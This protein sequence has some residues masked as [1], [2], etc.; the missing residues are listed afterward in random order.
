MEVDIDGMLVN[1]QLPFKKSINLKK[2][3]IN[4]FNFF[5]SHRFI[6]ISIYKKV[7]KPITEKKIRFI[8][9]NFFKIDRFFKRLFNIN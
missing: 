9:K 2:I 4:K 1:A 5:F 6:Y 3:F 8:N 7:N